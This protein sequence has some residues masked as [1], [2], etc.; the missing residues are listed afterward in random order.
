MN[1]ERGRHVHA[2]LRAVVERN[3]CARPAPDRQPDRRRARMRRENAQRERRGR[4]QARERKKGRGARRVQGF[5]LRDLARGCP[6]APL[7]SR[8][9]TQRPWRVRRCSHARPSHA[10]PHFTRARGSRRRPRSGWRTRC[11]QQRAHAARRMR[12]DANTLGEG[13][14]GHD[15]DEEQRLLR[16]RA[17]QARELDVLVPGG[18]AQGGAGCGVRARRRRAANHDSRVTARAR[19]QAWPITTVAQWP[20]RGGRC[21]AEHATH[22]RGARAHARNTIE[23]GLRPPG[24]ARRGRRS[25]TRPRRRGARCGA[26]W[27]ARTFARRN[28]WR[29]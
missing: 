26:R 10:T 1:G 18:G 19:R 4:G 28:A 6:T 27:Q 17:L 2:K 8:G 9:R 13:M 5:F 20:G 12:T 23:Q 29:Q 14:R 22:A 16:V 7:K 3:A 21:A 15:D 25:L 11:S 24:R